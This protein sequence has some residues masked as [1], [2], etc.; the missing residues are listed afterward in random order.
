MNRTGHNYRG[1]VEEASRTCR[2]VDS[3]RYRDG[4]DGHFLG[5]SRDASCA[6]YCCAE[7]FCILVNADV[8]CAVDE[9]MMSRKKKRSF[10]REWL[11]RTKPKRDRGDLGV[12]SQ[13]TASLVFVLP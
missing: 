4:E 8:L 13:H 12:V 3:C 5:A 9:A 7:A 1:A 2:Q 6:A 10:F 11:T